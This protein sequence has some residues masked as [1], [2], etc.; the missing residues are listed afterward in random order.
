MNAAAASGSPVTN[1]ASSA[2]FDASHITPDGTSE[3]APRIAGGCR[4][5]RP[6]AVGQDA[7]PLTMSL[8]EDGMTAGLHVGA[9]LAVSIAG[10][11]I[12]APSVGLARPQVP[13]T[14]STLMPWLSTTKII[15]AIAVAQQWE[16]GEFD[17]DE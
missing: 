5:Y 9:Q 13:M 10:E 3:R 16:R 15:T 11:V 8:I 7:L 2:S 1:P 14:A 4:R 17:L 12:A 6:Q